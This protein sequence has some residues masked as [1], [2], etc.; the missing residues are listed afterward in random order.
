MAPGWVVI[1]QM[2]MGIWGQGRHGGNGDKVMLGSRHQ[3]DI[4]GRWV[5]VR[6]MGGEVDWLSIQRSRRWEELVKET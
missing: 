2:E 6:E 1:P 3:F 4:K 5:D